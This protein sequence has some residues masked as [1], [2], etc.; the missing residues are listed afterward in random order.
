MEGTRG[1]ELTPLTPSLCVTFENPSEMPSVLLLTSGII[2][3]LR[4][5]SLS[6]SKLSLHP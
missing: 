5:E 4:G 6:A 1:V 3:V 2:S